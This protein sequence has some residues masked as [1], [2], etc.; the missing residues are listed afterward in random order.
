M[1]DVD[2]YFEMQKQREYEARLDEEEQKVIRELDEYLSFEGKFLPMSHMQELKPSEA[3]TLGG[4]VI[5]QFY[6]TLKKYFTEKAWIDINKRISDDFGQASHFDDYFDEKFIQIS[7]KTIHTENEFAQMN[8]AR[9]VLKTQTQDQ[10]RRKVRGIHG[11][12]RLKS[13]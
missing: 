9:L 6:L 8:M 2:E 4:P 3:Q 12:V 1:A 10:A 7:R 5:S 11:Y 13:I